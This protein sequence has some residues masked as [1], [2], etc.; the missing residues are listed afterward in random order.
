[1]T[2]H[3][4]IFIHGMGTGDPCASYQEL[5]E[6]I[7]SQYNQIHNL[8]SGG[9]EQLFKLVP[10]HYKD[11]TYHAKKDIYESAF[12]ELS[13]DDPTVWDILNPVQFLH[14]FVTFFLGD[15]TA[16][17]SENDNHIRSTFWQQSKEAMLN[18]SYSIIA[19]SL[20]S[21]IA[22]DFL[23]HLLERDELFLPTPEAESA[24][25]AAEQSAFTLEMT[26]FKQKKEQI[27][28]NF[29]N[30]FTFGSTIGLFMM[31]QGKLWR[32]LPTFS[33]IDNP[34]IKLNGAQNIRSWLNF[35]DRQDIL[36]YPL[37]NLFN[38]NPQNADRALK[39]IEVQTGNLVINSHINYWQNQDMARKIAQT[40]Q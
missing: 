14:Y 2:R 38:R 20:G 32:K 15:V 27:V 39:D 37:E 17:V 29:A 3:S 10:I 25:L 19:H 12:P 1:M 9:F 21:V 36:A 33:G 5:W 13:S 40:L 18:G 23:Y 22:F 6:S 7:A 35:Y 26:D 31:R 4:L 30:F 16:Y 24:E 28:S 8:D 11:I 34:V